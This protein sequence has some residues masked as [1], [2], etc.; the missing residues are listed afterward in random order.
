MINPSDEAYEIAGE[1]YEDDEIDRG[2]YERLYVQVDGERGRAAYIH[3]RAQ[4]IQRRFD[5]N[6]ASIRKRRESCRQTF[7]ELEGAGANADEFIENNL[8]KL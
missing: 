5:E 3:R 6:E 4:N 7:L 2:L 1:K 8:V